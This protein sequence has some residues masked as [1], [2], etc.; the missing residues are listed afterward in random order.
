[1]SFRLWNFK[2]GG[3]LN[4]KIFDQK[5][6]YSRKTLKWMSVL[7]NLGMLLKLKLEKIEKKIKNFSLI[8]D[9]ENWLWNYDFGTFWPTTIH[10]KKHFLWVKIFLGATI[11]ETPQPDWHYII[12]GR[13]LTLTVLTSKTF[14]HISFSVKVMKEIIKL[15]GEMN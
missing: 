2:Y 11:F 7:L 15:S 9:F 6:I 5:T 13:S 12:V 3:S 8:F 1:M 10:Q 4:S 14:I